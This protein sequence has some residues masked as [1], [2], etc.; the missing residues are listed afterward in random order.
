MYVVVAFIL[1][2]MMEVTHIVS[3]LSLQLLGA[4]HDVRMCLLNVV[5]GAARAGRLALSS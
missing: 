3:F 2:L 5:Q 1:Q 4:S